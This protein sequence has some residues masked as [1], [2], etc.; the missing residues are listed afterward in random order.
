MDS[1]L[2]DSGPAVRPVWGG[3]CSSARGNSVCE[4]LF[5]LHAGDAAGGSDCRVW[6]GEALERVWDLFS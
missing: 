2:R 1:A 6:Q 4:L 3:V 5:P